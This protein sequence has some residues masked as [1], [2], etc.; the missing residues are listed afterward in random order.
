MAGPFFAVRIPL[1][2]PLLESALNPCGRFRRNHGASDQQWT[3]PIVEDRGADSLSGP[4]RRPDG[5]AN[6]RE[7]MDRL[8]Q[9]VRRAE[10]AITPHR[11]ASDLDGLK[12]I[13]DFHG[14]LAEPRTAGLAA[15]MNGIAVRQTWP[16]ATAATICRRPN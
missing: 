1:E 7:F 13:N 4:A 15:V 10:A 12:R 11:S 9:E 14:H 8:E 6:Y 3:S 2:K 16:Y 5:L